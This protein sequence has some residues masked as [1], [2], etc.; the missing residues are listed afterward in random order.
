MSQQEPSIAR[1]KQKIVLVFGAF[2]LFHPGH[3]YF[4][5]EAVKHGDRLVVVVARDKNVEQ[6]KGDRPRE[7]E[8][9]RRSNV[10][11]F[12]VV[13]EARLGY[14]DWEQREQVLQDIEPDIICL[15]YDQRVEVPEGAWKVVRI[16]AFQPEK[17]KTSLM[18][19]KKEAAAAPDE[20]E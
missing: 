2:D 10:E 7:D 17:Y 9:V 5:R 15:G 19:E 20:E 6:L 8:E 3:E 4:L 1:E 13:D 18:R 11:N 16:E 14:E 12:E